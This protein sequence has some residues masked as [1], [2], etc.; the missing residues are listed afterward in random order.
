MIKDFISWY[1]SSYK[2]LCKGHLALSR[3]TID[4]ELFSRYTDIC[5]QPRGIQLS[6]ARTPKIT[7]KEDI[8]AKV[9]Y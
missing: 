7:V 3:A 6:I 8:C 5:N 4:F 9:L 2:H 1:Y